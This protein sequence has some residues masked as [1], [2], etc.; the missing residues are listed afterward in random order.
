MKEKINEHDMTKKMMSVLR[1][2]YKSKLLSED[3]NQEL[4]PD[5]DDQKDTI[6][7][8]KGDA[9]FKDELKKLQDIVD[10]SVEITNFKI[11]PSD[12]N[13]LIE[14]RLLEGQAE[15]SGIMFTMELK[16]RE[17]ETS[18]NNIELD[19]DVSGVLSR[20]QGYYK[21]WCNEWAKKITSEFNQ[22]KD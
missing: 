9:V 17:V 22:K 5:D 12:R 2:G 1:G 16:K 15:D 14:G 8:T 13:V 3:A 18:M 6:S 21:N 7:P 19:D 11:Y 4:K 10:P 20:I